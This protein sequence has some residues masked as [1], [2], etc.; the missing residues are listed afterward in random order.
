MTR[1]QRPAA[2]AARTLAAAAQLEERS[3]HSRSPSSSLSPPPPTP[4]GERDEAEYKQE[5]EP[6][7]PEPEEVAPAPKAKR[8]AKT[9]VKT[10]TDEA[11]PKKKRTRKSK[12]PPVY[13]IPPMEEI[14]TNFK[15]RLGYACL[16]TI[17]RALK[18]PVFCSR[19][20]RIDTIKNEDKGMPYLKELGRQNMMDLKQIIEWNVEH[21]IFFMRMSSEM[22]PFAGH[23]EYGYSLDYA[24]KELKE[25]GDTAKRLG[26]RL[27]THPGQFN[28]LGSPRRP[29]VENTFRDLEY[30]NEMMDR[31][32]LDK[33]SVMII[34]GGGVYNDKPTTIE[35]FK[36]VYKELSEG[37][38]ARL[39]LENDEMCFSV[40]DLLPIC[41]ELNIPLVLDYHHDWIYP[42]SQ[43]LSELMPRIV[44]TWT[45]KGIRPKFHL[46]EPRRGAETLMERRAHADRCQNL[47]SP[48]PED[49]DLMIEAKDKEQAVF[50]LFRRYGLQPV[51]HDS[52]RPP[53]L[54]ETTQT[55]G[56][57]SSK[58]KTPKKGAKE[59]DDDTA[60]DGTAGTVP[61]SPINGAQL[62]EIKKEDGMLEHGIAPLPEGVNA[63]GQAINPPI[64][65]VKLEDNAATTPATQGKTNG[66]STATPRKKA[67]T[68]R[69]RKAKEDKAGD[70]PAENSI[71][72]EEDVK[73]AK[74]PR[75]R[76]PRAKKTTAP[77]AA[78]SPER[79][80]VKMEE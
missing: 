39:V 59:E 5:P 50:H 71:G 56:R 57:K 19:T 52:L 54:E 75:T 8:K 29:V 33:D 78:T 70:E 41:E 16:N 68:P 45:R 80:A 47:P 55:A 32:G 9:A 77:V 18:P 30:H 51:F 67:A 44:A 64:N 36:G 38:K 73:P 35:R 21:K 27:T 3:R 46:S 11:T 60:T 26:V 79:V 48:L 74:K 2:I 17:L 24:E 7:V 49:I 37:V 76:T 15:G 12:E 69:K 62:D 42:S 10:E 63:E 23:A 53:A 1:T 65:G 66:K 20:C 22:F 58:K 6:A 43:P 13:V 25:A 28:Q 61:S 72:G 40:D 14:T 4:P 34:H 31:M